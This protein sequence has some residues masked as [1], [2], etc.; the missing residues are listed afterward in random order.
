MEEEEEDEDRRTSRSLLPLR[1]ELAT[2]STNW[3][4]T[5]ELSRQKGLNPVMTSFLF[6]MLQQILPTKERVAKFLPN[7]SP[8]CTRCGGVPTGWLWTVSPPVTECLTHAMFH[9]PD[10]RV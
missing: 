3:E 2:P 10:R 8:L 4:R 6:M 5:W 7:S 1:V 9:C